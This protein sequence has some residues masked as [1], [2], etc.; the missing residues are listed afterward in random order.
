MMF[1]VWAIFGGFISH[2]LLANYLSVLLRPDFEK[3]VET[4][5]DLIERDLTPFYQPGRDFLI[6]FFA[7][8][9]SPSFRQLSKTL[10]I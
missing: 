4:A 5:E 1:L 8:S 3:P 2:F 10:I 6:Q 9:P 7:E